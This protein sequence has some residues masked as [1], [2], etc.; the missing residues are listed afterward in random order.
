[1]I[2]H[3]RAGSARL[4]LALAAAVV[5]LLPAAPVRALSLD[6][7]DA[8]TTS[9][10]NGGIDFSI[11]MTASEAPSRVEIHLLFPGAI[12]PFVV[13]LADQ[14]AVSFQPKAG[15]N[16]LHYTL[17]TSAGGHIMPN[18]PITTTWVA[19][20]QGGG[21]PFSSDPSTYH[22]ADETQQW[23]TL[24]DGIVTVHWTTGSES[25]AQHAASVAVKALSTN[26][27]V[28]GIQET[29]PVDFFI[30]ADDASFRAALGA[31]AR[32]NV[33]GEA[34]TEIRTLFA[35]FTPDLLND[36]WV[37]IT[38]THELTHQVVDD[39]TKNPYRSLPRWLNEGFAVYQSEGNASKY[40]S[41]VK[42]AVSSGD[43]LPLTALGWQFPTEPTKTVLAYAESV[44]AVDYIVRQYGKDALTKLILAY[45]NGP[46]DDEAMQAAIGK[47][48]AAFQ[49]E[50]F[51][52]VGASTPSPFGP[53]PGPSGPLPSDWLGAAASQAPLASGSAAPSTGAATPTAASTA[54]AAPTA[55]PAPA[56]DGSSGSDLTAVLVA[57]LVVAGVVLAGIVIAGRRTSS[58]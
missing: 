15:T 25:F 2:A 17:D 24:R 1:M 36:P 5:L 13:N 57:V 6:F 28:L 42:D 32:E 31:G 19:Y 22:Y 47:D 44:S 45:K 11:K 35:E 54:G 43:L 39:A 58:P 34:I 4:L 30:Y 20:M 37:G 41:M 8:T 26:A 40:R 52:A 51:G 50:W 9:A 7:S 10:F 27:A 48:V 3:G 21:A 12:G 33:G 38:I 56:P 14:P 46:T 29:D 49:T 53:Q 23:Q 16:T 18:T 55:S